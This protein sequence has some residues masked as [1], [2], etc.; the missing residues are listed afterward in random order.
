MLEL[1]RYFKPVILRYRSVRDLWD[2]Y[3]DEFALQASK[4]R[5]GEGWEGN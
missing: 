4:G 1:G 3:R 2:T 5:G